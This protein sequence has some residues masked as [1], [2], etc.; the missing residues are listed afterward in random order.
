MGRIDDA[1]FF[2]PGE[3][4][5]KIAKICF[6]ACLVLTVFLLVFGLLNCLSA[7]SEYTSFAEVM[8]YTEVDYVNAIA[9]END[10]IIHGYTGQIMLKAAPLAALAAIYSIPLY[11]FGSLVDDVIACKALL[12]VMKN[13]EEKKAEKKKEDNA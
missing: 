2:N 9:R 7:T 3:T 11:A 13:A 12:I 4:V 6:Y 8:A 5:R 10:S 1:L